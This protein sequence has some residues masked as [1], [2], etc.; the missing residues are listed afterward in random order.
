MTSHVLAS[1][2]FSWADRAVA[3]I[4]RLGI[5]LKNRRDFRILAEMSD[6]ELA[7]IGLT[8][9][10]LAYVAELPFTED[11]T[12]RLGRVVRRRAA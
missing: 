3:A 2:R 11:P 6:I 4:A 1:A 9:S 5:I 8:R 7:D 12:A 10:D